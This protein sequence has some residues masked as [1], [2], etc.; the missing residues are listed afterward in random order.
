LTVDE[1]DDDVYE[2]DDVQIYRTW[3]DYV[4]STNG[5]NPAVKLMDAALGPNQSGDA[6]G[7]NDLAYDEVALVFGEKV[8][9]PAIVVLN[10]DTQA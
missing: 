10:V 4:N 1:S 7:D 2:I 5:Y 3:E 8:P 9:A 6:V